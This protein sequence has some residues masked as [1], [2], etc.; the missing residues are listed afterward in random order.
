MIIFVVELFETMEKYSKLKKLARFYIVTHYYSIDY[1]H[2]SCFLL[3]H[4][5]FLNTFSIYA[6]FFISARVRRP[7]SPHA[8][9]HEPEYAG[10]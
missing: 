10:L 6:S 5:I 2:I 8:C 9:V 4:F 3:Y 7:I 1:H